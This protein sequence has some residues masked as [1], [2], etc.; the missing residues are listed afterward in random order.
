MR[1]YNVIV[2]IV[3][4]L[5][6]IMCTN[7]CTSSPGADSLVLSHQRETAQL[8]AR[9]ADYQ[10]RLEQYD[11]V[12]T[13]STEQLETIRARTAG[14]LGTVDELIQLFGEYQREVERLISAYNAIKNTTIDSNQSSNNAGSDTA[15]TTN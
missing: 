7:G 11:S 12:V 15:T 9:I 6:A 13:A 1:T 3:V 14:S 8:E 4:I 10:R 5:V 2:I